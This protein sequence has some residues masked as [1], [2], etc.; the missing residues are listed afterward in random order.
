MTNF[1][2]IRGSAGNDTINDTE[3]NDLLLGDAGDDTLNANIGNDILA[4]DT[5][6][7]TLTGGAGQDYFAFVDDPFSGGAPTQTG[8][9][10]VG[11]PQGQGIQF[12]NKPDIV[13]DYR[14]GEDQLLFSKNQVGIEQFQITG[15]SINDLSD[16]QDKNLFLLTDRFNSAADAA[17]GLANN[18][19]VTGDEGLFVYFN[20]NLGIGRVV[21]SEDLGDGGTISVIANLNSVTNPEDISRL[22]FG[23]Y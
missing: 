10:V 23:L 9:F 17:G 16:G 21:Y 14:V 22:N 18:A 19:S 8:G 15:G 5:G 11:R 2:P 4:G 13:T 7:D 6:V 20:Q 12:L 1:N 3:G